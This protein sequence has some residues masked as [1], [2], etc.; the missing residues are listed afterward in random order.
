MTARQPAINIAVPVYNGAAHLGEALDSL[1]AQTFSNFDLLIVD[2]ASTDGTPD[3]CAEYARRDSRV[4]V[5]RHARNIGGPRN[6]SFAARQA[7][8]APYFKW[9]AANDVCHPD[10]LARCH[11]TL[12]AHPE[13]VLAYPRARLIDEAGAPIE[14]YEDVLDLRDPDPC[15]RFIRLL[16]TVRLNNAQNG[17]IRTAPLLR[18]GLEAPYFSSDITLLAELVL[19]GAFVEIPDVLFYRRIAAGS[20]LFKLSRAEARRFNDPLRR[21][22]ASFPLWRRGLGRLAAV[23]RAPLA[24]RQRGRLWWF[25]LR[26]MVSSRDELWSELVQEAR[27][28]APRVGIRASQSRR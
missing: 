16:K 17:L 12:E 5:H 19:H 21:H 23:A 8:R 28:R 13:A 22:G 6:W 7:A 25:V 27:L 14:D 3:I 24:L 9:A 2:N 11:E 4:R 15:E 26:D 1:L 18:T 10:M 20:T